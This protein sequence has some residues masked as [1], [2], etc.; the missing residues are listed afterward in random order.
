[1][2]AREPAA[3]SAP[4]A[5]DVD[6]PR[7]RRIPRWCWRLSRGGPSLE[8]VIRPRRGEGGRLGCR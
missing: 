7:P 8:R 4:W 3:V 1:M 2:T 6:G 5:H